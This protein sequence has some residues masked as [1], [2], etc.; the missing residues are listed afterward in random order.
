MYHRRTK[1]INIYYHFARKRVDNGELVI[2]FISS[3]EQ[4]A[5]IFTK[6]LPKVQ[7]RKLCEAIKII[8]FCKK[9]SNSGSVNV[10]N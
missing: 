4:R 10:K 7:F 8:P 2:N 5:D 9:C 1:H 6:A 3:E